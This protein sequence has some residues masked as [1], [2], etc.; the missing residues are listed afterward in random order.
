M[1]EISCIRPR[2]WRVSAIDEATA[3]ID[4]QIVINM[5]RRPHSGRKN[6]TRVNCPIARRMSPEPKQS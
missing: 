2:K 4:H 3:N 1:D 5:L 6:V